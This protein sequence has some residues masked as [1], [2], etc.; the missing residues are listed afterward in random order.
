M[1]MMI[2]FTWTMFVHCNHEAVCSLSGRQGILH[3][4]QTKNM[5]IFWVVCPCTDPTPKVNRSSINAV[6]MYQCAAI[7]SHL[8]EW[9]PISSVLRRCRPAGRGGFSI[10]AETVL[11][12]GG[13]VQMVWKTV[14]DDWRSNTVCQLPLLCSAL[15]DFHVPQ[16]RVQLC[17]RFAVGMKTCRKYAGPAPRIQLNARNAILH[18]VRWGTSRQCRTSWSTGVIRSYLLQP[19]TIQTTDSDPWWPTTSTVVSIH[20]HTQTTKVT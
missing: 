2:V 15:S 17:R 5:V 9:Y 6:Y 12:D 3:T 16:N 19:V 20:L 13:W 14:P 18:C 8:W 11:W 7:S 10:H 1:I 4:H